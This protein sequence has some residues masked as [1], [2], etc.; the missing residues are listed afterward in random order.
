MAR[1][2]VPTAVAVFLLFV[3]TWKEAQYSDRFRDSSVSEMEFESRFSKV[4]KTLGPWKGKDVGVTEEVLEV[5]GAV[6]HVNRTYVNEDT[7]EVVDL[8]LIVGHSRDIC[9]HTPDICYPSQGFS[10]IGTP[11]QQ[12]IVLSDGEEAGFN[13]AK[14]RNESPQG[15]VERRVF[16]SWNA[17]RE[18]QQSWEAPEPGWQRLHFG[19]N[20]GL[21]KLYFTFTLPRGKDEIVDNPAVRFAK[22]MLPEIN[23]ALFEDAPS[24]S[25]GDPGAAA[26]K[27]AAAAPGA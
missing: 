12:K 24:K 22:A 17:N 6:S 25:A 10:P 2:Y 20:S 11:V 3:L 26:E 19:N 15:L 5:A 8:W 16:W 18:G 1:L 9:R 27:S 7:G 4:P 13:T 23:R 21:Y 14:F